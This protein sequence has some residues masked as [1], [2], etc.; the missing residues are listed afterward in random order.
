MIYIE[1]RLFGNWIRLGVFGEPLP[2]RTTQELAPFYPLE[3]R[4]VTDH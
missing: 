4:L 3:T 1:V 2:E